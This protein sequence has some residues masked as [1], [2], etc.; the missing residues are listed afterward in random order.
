MRYDSILKRADKVSLI[1][2]RYD[3]EC[4]LKRNRYIVDKSELVIAIFNGIEKG[5]AWYTISYAKKRNKVIEMIELNKINNL[6]E[7]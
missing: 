5:G 2:K 1:S 6:F 4:M 7:K 3:T